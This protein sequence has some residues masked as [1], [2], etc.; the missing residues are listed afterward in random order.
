M[1]YVETAK[2]TGRSTSGGGFLRITTLR[3][4]SDALACALVGLSFGSACAAEETPPGRSSLS[5]LFE[6]DVF[7]N[8]DRDYTNGVGFAYTTAPAETPSD[9]VKTARSLPKL[10]GPGEV[11]ASFALGQE[12]FTPTHT[13]RRNPPPTE[14]PY[15]GFL[16]A[17][18]SLL[19]KDRRSLNQLEIQFGVVGPASFARD[20]QVFV[21]SVLGKAKPKGWGHQLHNEPVLQL[22][23]ERAYKIIPPQSVIGLSFDFQP[24]VGAAAGNVYD[25]VNAGAMARFGLNLPDDFGPQRLQPSLPGSNFFD[26]PAAFSAYVFAGVDGRAVARNL[27]LDGNTFRRSPKVPKN[28]FFGDLQLGFAIATREWRLSF[29]HVYR[30]REYQAQTKS[31]QFGAIN[32]TVLL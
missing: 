14:Q 9:L 19:T 27:F 31:D 7:F 3:A 12:I 18:V 24:H 2:L 22:H 15:A 8:T 4:A 21:H 26:P 23:F 16:W 29:S 5:V 1:R 28:A 32:V 20:A 6:N 30:S 11:R 25:Y 10:L 13:E 17:G